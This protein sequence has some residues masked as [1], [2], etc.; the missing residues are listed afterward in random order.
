MT[1]PLETPLDVLAGTKLRAARESSSVEIGRVSC[2]LRAGR[3]GV[4]SSANS[5]HAA[6]W[7]Q[8]DSGPPS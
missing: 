4:G 2:H 6:A 7:L 1:T 3:P 5:C 8:E